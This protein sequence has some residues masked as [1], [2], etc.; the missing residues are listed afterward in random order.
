M[1]ALILVTLDVRQNAFCLL[2]E[3]QKGFQMQDFNI[4]D[5]KKFSL[6]SLDIT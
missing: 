1:N 6:G 4:K 5:E 2:L 3:K